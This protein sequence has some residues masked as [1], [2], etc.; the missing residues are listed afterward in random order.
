MLPGGW[1]NYRRWVTAGLEILPRS[2]RFFRLFGAPGSA[3][4]RVVTAL[5][6][7]GHQVIDMASV[8]GLG[9]A[10]GMPMSA[11]TRLTQSGFETRVLDALRTMDIGREVWVAH[12]EITPPDLCWPPA[13]RSALNRASTVRLDVPLA[14][15]VRAWR[16]ELKA[17]AITG[18]RLID[19]FKTVTPAVGMPILDKWRRTFKDHGIEALLAAILVGFIDASFVAQETD[20]VNSPPWQVLSVKSLSAASLA[21]STLALNLQSPVELRLGNG[22]ISP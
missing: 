18:D 6:G 1:I 21:E 2:M 8:S 19:L 16:D 10:P 5:A 9:I 13:L 17:A 3:T 12:S 7:N 15:R 20:Q 22:S 4:Q 14:V 11:R